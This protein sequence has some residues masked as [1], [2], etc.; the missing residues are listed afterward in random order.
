MHEVRMRVAIPSRIIAIPSHCPQ[1]MASRMKMRARTTVTAEKVEART[2]VT[3][4]PAPWLPA[5]IATSA[6]PS[7]TP[8]APRA[9]HQ[10]AKRNARHLATQGEQKGATSEAY[11]AAEKDRLDIAV[12]GP[13]L[14]PGRHG[15]G[16]HER[17]PQE[18]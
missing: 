18:K 1:D 16:E 8:W 3:A 12:D 5:R 4:E 2:A 10:R 13:G 7:S 9:G 17:R 6:L 15:H 14:L 11:P